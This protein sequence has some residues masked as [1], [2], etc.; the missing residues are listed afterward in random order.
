MTIKSLKAKAIK[1]QT[2]NSAL[3]ARE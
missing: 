1:I 2:F 3:K